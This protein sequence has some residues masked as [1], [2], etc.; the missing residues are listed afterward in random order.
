MMLRL[1]LV[2]LVSLQS[3]V[4]QQAECDG[5]GYGPDV[6]TTQLGVDMPQTCYEEDETGNTRC[7][8]TYVPPCAEGKPS[9]L[10]MILHGS[11]SC[12]VVNANENGWIQK[13]QEECF[14]I[15][16]PMGNMVQTSSFQLEMNC[17]EVPGGLNLPPAP[18]PDGPETEP[19]CCSTE[20]TTVPDSMDLDFL[21]KVMESVV[22]EQMV[23]LS[24]IYLS[25]HS[26]G[27]ILAHAYH[28]T[29][30]DIV[31]AMSCTA[32]PA[33]TPIPD[34]YNPTPQLSIRGQLDDIVAYDGL[35]IED[36]LF[37][38]FLIFPSADACF[39]EYLQANGCQGP[40]EAD[41]TT[42]DVP[43]M[44]LPNVTATMEHRK[45]QGCAADTELVILNTAGHAIVNNGIEA[46]AQAANTTVDITSL[47]WDF[48]ARQSRSEPAALTATADAGGDE[49][50]AA[51]GEPDTADGEPDAADAGG[52][53]TDTS[54]GEPSTA[55]GEP[56]ASSNS[57]EG[58]SI[59]VVSVG[60][61]AVVLSIAALI[62]SFLAY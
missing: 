23:D 10:L 52:N 48:V 31:A 16:Y 29:Y 7:Y 47:M 2:A 15:V 33:I 54:D 46:N 41:S 22:A 53:G 4:A 36:E 12:P 51:D 8:H 61:H 37:G 25:G 28:R 55:D 44:D 60:P 6:L 5:Y 20:E 30:S 59:G 57:T 35:L 13:A 17:W 34:S 24:R 3:V 1:A 26:N 32:A 50:D 21:H 19:C 45:G 14:V 9:P 39:E 18:I 62:C 43:E 42:V 27:C 58:E 11:E 38:E 40:E 49:T 56:S